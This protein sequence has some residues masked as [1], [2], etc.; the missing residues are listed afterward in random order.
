[1]KM[2]GGAYFCRR[3]AGKG[4][5]VAGQGVPPIKGKAGLIGSAAGYEYVHSPSAFK[6]KIHPPR[7]AIAQNSMQNETLRGIISQ[8]GNKSTYPPMRELLQKMQR[9]PEK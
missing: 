9:F 3:S 4:R 5:A 1:M 8:T 6:N 7:P 2:P